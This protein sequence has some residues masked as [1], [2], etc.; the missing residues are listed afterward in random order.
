MTAD[1][2]EPR[3]L[4]QAGPTAS[5]FGP[6][7][8]AEPGTKEAAALS[9]FGPPQDSSHLS[10][11][12]AETISGED[13][14]TVAELHA[15]GVAD[16][17]QR[18]TSYVAIVSDAPAAPEDSPAE[19][20]KGYPE[21]AA[22]HFGECFAHRLRW[23]HA[24]NSRRRLKGALAT[25]AHFI[26]ADVASGPLVEEASR[27]DAPAG[28]ARH[29]R[30]ESARGKDTKVCTASG[31]SIIMAHYPTEQSSDL[32]LERFMTAVLRHNE[33]IGEAGTVAAPIPSQAPLRRSR[34]AQRAEEEEAHPPNE[35]AAFARD[36]N[37][38]LDDNAEAHGRVLTAC[39][40]SRRDRPIVMTARRTC[41]GVKLDFKQFDCVAPTIEYLREI[42]A[43]K[44]LGGHLWLNA[45][46]FAGPGALISPLNAKDFVR[47]CAEKLPEAVLSLSWGASIISTTRLYT[48]DMVER[49]IELCMCPIV[50]RPLSC[51]GPVRGAPAER[52]P[53]EQQ[54][55]LD[56][57]KDGLFLAPAA[58]CNHITF[59][60]AAE[61][62][63]GSADGLRR[64]LEAVPGAS[65]TVFSGVGSLGIT[66]AHV[67]EL[68]NTYGDRRCFLDLRVSKPWRSC[69]NGS[70]SLQ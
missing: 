21:V 52:R 24:V 12:S 38:E 10:P 60:V 14:A 69:A 65:L 7:V 37:K 58:T 15:A 20:V 16:A 70:C 46:V 48:H 51:P 22:A 63:L 53:P 39:V 26:E 1:T 41:K 67:Q 59:A 30:L 54:N 8:L 66:P 9:P 13:D 44:K 28:A 6:P 4:A 5:P 33:R 47:L 23:A 27:N 49:M 62:A 18:P 19:R 57:F 34:T 32:S 25:S 31:K 29:P 2:A 11:S 45:D 40:G 61:Y 36:L 50:E 56:K 68:I 43:A 55:S 42:D 35:A 64:L 17:A 3:P